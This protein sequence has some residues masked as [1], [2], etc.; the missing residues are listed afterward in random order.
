MKKYSGGYVVQQRLT[1]AFFGFFGAAARNCG[2]LCRSTINCRMREDG[3]TRSLRNRTNAGATHHV[4]GRDADERMRQI[5]RI[6]GIW[7]RASADDIIAAKGNRAMSSVDDKSAAAT[8]AAGAITSGRACGTCSLCCKLVQITELNKP[9]GQWCPH[10]IKSGGC[11][12]YPTRP[13]ECRDFNCE[14]LK[15]ALIGDEWRPIRSKMVLINVQ[16]PAGQK[17]VVHV[18]SGSPL[19]WRNE[20]Y[21]GQ[22]KRWAADLLERNGMVNI[23]VRNRVIAVL[24]HE[25]V[26][27][28]VFQMGDRISLRRKWNG[29]AWDVEV[30]KVAA[31]ATPAP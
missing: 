7:P 14:W 5:L 11:A 1:P 21:Y 13:G 20:P 26:D 29:V 18:D 23:Y 16:E 6:G 24:P 12:I 2:M 30:L 4:M 17:L 31:D 9:M 3:S 19:A 28:G 8:S 25:D 15:N 10:C 22:L 27:L